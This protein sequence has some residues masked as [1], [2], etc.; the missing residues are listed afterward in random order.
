MDFRYEGDDRSFHVLNAVSPPRSR[1]ALS[2]AEYLVQRIAERLHVVAGRHHDRP[3]AVRR[4]PAPKPATAYRPT[5]T[6]KAS[7]TVI[8]YGLEYGAKIVV[9]PGW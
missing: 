3:P 2:L 1:A 4:G 8:A 9:G 6:Q 7:L 5:L